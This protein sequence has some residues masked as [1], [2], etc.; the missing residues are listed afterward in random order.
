MIATRK[1]PPILLILAIIAAVC[2]SGALAAEPVIHVVSKGETLYSIARRYDV[3]LDE[4]LRL[5]NIKDASKI[6]AGMKLTIPGS[7][8]DLDIS[9]M[10][11]VHVVKKN[12]TLYG[13]SK[14]YGVS[15][16]SIVQE[17]SLAGYTIK[18]GQNLKIVGTKGPSPVQDGGTVVKSAALPDSKTGS[19]QLPS[20]A[21]ANKIWPVDGSINPLQGKLRGVSISAEAGSSIMAIRAGT[22]VSAGPFRGFDQVAFVQS[23]DGLVYVYGGAD[24]LVVKP[25]DIVRKGSA[26]GRLAREQEASAYFFVF[27][28][29]ETIDPSTAP[30][31]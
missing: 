29:S 17:N 8:P 14:S 18:E 21:Y 28:G 24:S 15:V 1:T 25:G 6:F 7:G 26:I 5:N 3:I 27:K 4:L 13:I 12:E 11:I 19:N 20:G 9:G 31:D 30:R 16:D 23:S 22:V 2:S 10:E